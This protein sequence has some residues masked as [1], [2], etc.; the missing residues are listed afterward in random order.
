MNSTQRLMLLLRPSLNFNTAHP[1]MLPSST[2]LN[3][4]IWFKQSTTSNSWGEM[5]FGE[6]LR[7]GLW[8]SWGRVGRL[9]F[10][11][12][13]LWVTYI[14]HC[15]LYTIKCRQVN[16]SSLYHVHC[17]SYIVRVNSL[18]DPSKVELQY[19]ELRVLKMYTVHCTVYTNTYNNNNTLYNVQ[20]HYTVY[21]VHNVYKVLYTL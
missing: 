3:T 17:T 9:G 13:G 16:A 19:V 6:G 21:N 7:V 4:P 1:G 12:G 15:I 14:V 18:Y 5:T 8:A 11:R 10:N 2:K 20:S